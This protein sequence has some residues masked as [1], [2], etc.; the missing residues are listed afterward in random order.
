MNE[1]ELLEALHI[2]D[3]VREADL[4]LGTSI[5]D[6]IYHDAIRRAASD[7]HGR[8]Q[9]ARLPMPSPVRRPSFALAA[10]VAVIAFVIAVVPG[11]ISRAPAYAIRQLPD[12]K[13]EIDWSVDSYRPDAGA[14]AAE[15]RDIGVDVLI[16]TIP[17][18]PSAVGS[19]TGVFAQGQPSDGPPPGLVITEGTAQGLTWTID[20]KVLHGPVTLNVNVPAVPGERYLSSNSVFMPGEVLAGLQC[21]LGEPLH[22]TDVAARLPKLGITPIWD[23]VDPGSVSTDYYSEHQVSEVPNGVIFA[24]YAV[25]DAT[26]ELHVAPPGV[27]L[28]DVHAE[29]LSNTPC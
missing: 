13:I 20:P 12:G 10:L 23:V 18:S 4:T 9:H 16:T 2:A 7:L 8:P 29:P 11:L 5:R 26:V 15:L 19:V 25:D 28:A 1:T 6:R 24:G 3:P 21:T 27:S 14:I 22:P 17:A